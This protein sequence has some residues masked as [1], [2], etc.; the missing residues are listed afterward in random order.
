[1]R[2]R[3]WVHARPLERLLTLLFLHNVL[4][5]PT[6]PA[7]LW[8]NLTPEGKLEPRSLHAGCPVTSGSK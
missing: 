1:M 6:H 2:L 7:L 5:A 3:P 8:H 4:D